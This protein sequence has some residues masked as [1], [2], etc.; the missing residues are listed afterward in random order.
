MDSCA[1]CRIVEYLFIVHWS[2][3]CDLGRVLSTIININRL[4]GA[5]YPHTVYIQKYSM[6]ARARGFCDCWKLMLYVANIA[7]TIKTT[8]NP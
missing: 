1:C 4:D 2:L 8:K 5:T 3:D 7:F 6:R